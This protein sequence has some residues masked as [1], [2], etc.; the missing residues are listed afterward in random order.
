MSR[1]ELQIF[2]DDQQRQVDARKKLDQ[3]V[4]KYRRHTPQVNPT[5]DCSVESIAMCDIDASWID[6]GVAVFRAP[7]CDV[8]NLLYEPA[9]YDGSTLW[10]KEDHTLDKIVRVIQHWERSEGLAPMLLSVR[11]SSRLGLVIDG[12]HR[13]TVA[14]RMTCAEIPFMVPLKESDWILRAL[15]SVT[16]VAQYSSEDVRQAL[17]LRGEAAI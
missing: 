15:P 2:L 5:W 11:A 16:S 1:S 12:K 9:V 4:K 13:L 6:S 7:F 3:L 10:N 17:Q 14:H 8:W